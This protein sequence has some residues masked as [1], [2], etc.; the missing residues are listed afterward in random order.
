[1]P[2]QTDLAHEHPLLQ[3]LAPGGPLVVEAA[4]QDEV[5]VARHRPQPERRRALDQPVA[6]R[7][8]GLDGAEQV[9]GVRERRPGSRLGEAAQVVRQPDQAHRRGHAGVGG[10]VADARA[11]EGE[12]LAHGPRD[13]EPAPAGQQ[14]DGAGGTGPGVLGVGLVDD[15]HGG[16][17]RVVH[18]GDDVQVERGAGRV[19]GRAEE[20]HVGVD[21]GSLGGRRARTEAERVVL[22]AGTG[23]RPPT[24][25]PSPRRGSGA[26]STSA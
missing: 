21:L 6:L 23:S 8:G 4:D 17:G 5:R 14:R 9:V 15:H 1:V 24:G 18:S 25:S 20:D 19:V 12:R 16:R 10:Q 13:D 26:S 7:L 3:Q 2:G 11:G 22:A